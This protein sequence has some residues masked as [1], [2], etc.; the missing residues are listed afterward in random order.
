MVGT[1]VVSFG[2]SEKVNYLAVVPYLGE[3]G[4]GG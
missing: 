4:E 3:R 1:E 2:G